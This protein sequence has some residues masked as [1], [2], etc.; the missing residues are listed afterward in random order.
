MILTLALEVGADGQ[1]CATEPAS[2]RLVIDVAV[3]EAEN[4]RPCRGR[5]RVERHPAYGGRQCKTRRDSY[6]SVRSM[7]YW[8]IRLQSVLGSVC[9]MSRVGFHSI[10]RSL[11]LLFACPRWCETT[12]NTRT[13]K[14]AIRQPG[15]VSRR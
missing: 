13:I 6:M 1:D 7:I 10:S 3:R 12:D 5:A 11:D 2:P 14:E 9:V 15:G 8:A 4:G